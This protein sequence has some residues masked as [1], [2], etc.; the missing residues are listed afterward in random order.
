MV[1][2]LDN[3]HSI[4]VEATNKAD[5]Y[6]VTFYEDGRKLDEENGTKDYIEWWYGVTF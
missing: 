4:V 5:I 1:F 3:G 6:K 2:E